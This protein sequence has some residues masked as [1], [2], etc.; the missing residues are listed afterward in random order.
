[1]GRFCLLTKIS[2]ASRTAFGS[3]FGFADENI[4]TSRAEITGAFGGDKT[5]IVTVNRLLMTGLSTGPGQ[6]IQ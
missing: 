3:D 2:A 5:P 1:M 6:G 4:V